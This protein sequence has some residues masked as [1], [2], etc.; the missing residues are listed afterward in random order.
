V[1]DD[2]YAELRARVTKAVAAADEDAGAYAVV[3]ERRMRVYM[4]LQ[5]TQILILLYAPWMWLKVCG[6][7]FY[8]LYR[9]RTAWTIIHERVHRA[10]L[11]TT[12]AKLFYDFSTVFIVRFWKAHHLQ[13]HAHTN[14]PRDPDTKMFFGRDMNDARGEPKGVVVRAVRFV[15]TL[16]QYPFLYA[17]FLIRSLATYKGGN[18]IPYLATMVVYSSA[19][20][21]L[22]PRDV[23]KLNSLANLGLGALYI[24]LTFVPTHSATRENFLLP[25][26]PLRDQLVATND[27]W[28]HSRVWSFLC[29]GIN[30]HIEHHLFPYL[31]FHQLRRAAPVVEAFAREKGLPYNAYSPASIWRAHLGFL[32][33]T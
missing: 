20:S 16:V 8:A 33:R 22:L 32:W 26:D 7:I 10:E 23:A 28:P 12:V 19:V 6:A 4:A 2:D 25:G 9:A 27:V 17:L 18:T 24:L 3:L 15:T 13:H 14:T 1:K 30:L 31:P 21:F 11:P 29:G 5:I